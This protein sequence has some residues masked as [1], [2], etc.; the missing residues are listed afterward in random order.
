MKQRILPG[1]TFLVCMLASPCFAQAPA[2]GVGGN[3]QNPEVKTIFSFKDEVGLTDD[4]ESKLKVLLYDEQTT[5][6]AHNDTLKG[7]G[8]ELSKLIESKAE[9]SLIK[10]KL[11]AISKIQVEVSCI[12]IEDARKIETILTPEQIE[13]WKDIQKKFSS[14]SKA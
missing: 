3:S 12:N 13:K 5:V 4:Q 2:A 10:S 1:L 9:M 14:Q 11:E 8:A 6:N 7:L